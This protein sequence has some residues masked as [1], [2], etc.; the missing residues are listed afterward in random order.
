M[1]K[2]AKIV[3]IIAL[4]L[5]VSLVSGYAYLQHQ[6]KSL[7]ITNLKYAIHQINYKQIE[8]SQLSFT[9]LEPELDV[10]LQNLKLN[11][12]W[13]DLFSPSLDLLSLEQGKLR[14]KHWPKSSDKTAEN[15]LSLPKQWQFP[16]AIPKKII[17]NQLQLQLPCA[18]QLCS[19]SLNATATTQQQQLDYLIQ[20]ADS[21]KP[22]LV[23]SQVAGYINTANDLAS[24]YADVAIDDSIS[25]SLQQ[26]FS[27]TAEQLNSSSNLQLTAKPPSTWL[28]Q[29]LNQWQLSLPPS[30]LEQFTA[31]ININSQ[32]QLHFPLPLDTA[33]F[34]Q[35]LSGNW[36]F[37]ADLPSEFNIP[38]V[39]AIKGNLTAQLSLNQGDISNYQLQ[40]ALQLNQLQFSNSLKQYGMDIE[41]ILLELNADSSSQPRLEALPIVANIKTTGTSQAKINSKVIIN[42]SDNFSVQLTEVKLQLQ[43][44][45]LSYE[46][47]NNEH[48]KLDQLAIDS[49][50][51]AFWQASKWQLDLSQLTATANQ[52]Q[53]S[54][55]SAQGLKL[56]LQPSHFSSQQ[57]LSI[58]SQFKL[59]IANLKHPELITQAWQY[60]AKVAGDIN[61]VS[62]VGRLENTANLAINHQGVYSA[63]QIKIDWQLDEMFLLASNPLAASFVQWPALLEFNR[64]KIL[65]KG[66]L[67]FSPHQTLLL[68][69]L[70]LNDLSGI[71][72]RG[73]FKALTAEIAVDYNNDNVTLAIPQAKLAE[74]S[75]GV[76]LGPILLSANYTAK[77]DHILNGILDLQHLNI[78]AMGGKVSA[79]PVQLDLTKQ[80][81]I[82]TLQL[83]KIDL[84]KIL[85]QHPTSDLTGNGLIS[86]TIPL[87]ISNKGIRVD[88]GHIAAESP[89]GALQYRPAAASG[90]AAGNQSMKVVLDALDNFHYS[91]LSSNVSYDAAGKLNLALSIQGSNPSFE[92]GRS[93]NFNINLEEDLP[94]LITSMQLNNEISEKIK[95]RVQQRLQQKA[96]KASNG[97]SP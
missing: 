51:S 3:L 21:A 66:K 12:H 59:D 85:Q 64:G 23:R 65:A 27:Q 94:A 87:L 25:L 4:L 50:F 20:L 24:I 96:A 63:K 52:V 67:N 75:Q 1:F 86:G 22:N 58:D 61:N 2:L 28:Q 44:A 6:L 39:G 14:L 79:V 90:M 49:E 8:F 9:L 73:I 34:V 74:F 53:F 16:K 84:A 78:T 92:K 7:P 89:G 17:I 38:N 60:Q 26:Q 56:K 33:K 77:N 11:W 47:A 10:Q 19:Y 69:D 45:Q 62:L 42:A 37:N 76:E 43:Q 70:T 5:A 82:I 40:S 83:D 29:Q 18:D 71:Y 81:Q 93:I 41:A 57:A 36:Q 88:K 48:I 55:V 13:S 68:A 72:D 80:Q 30:T 54:E 97:E 91:V 46:L 95:R 31:P 32:A 15:K 35:Q